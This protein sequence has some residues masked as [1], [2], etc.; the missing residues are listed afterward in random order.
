MKRSQEIKKDLQKAFPGVVFSVVTLGENVNVT[1]GTPTKRISADER[2]NIMN[3]CHDES[4]FH[5][6]GDGRVV[7]KHILDEIVVTTWVE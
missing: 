1:A 4:I 7:S 3:Y 5:G 6:L 2:I